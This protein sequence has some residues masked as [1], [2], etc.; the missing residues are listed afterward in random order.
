MVSNSGIRSFGQDGEDGG[1]VQEPA[2]KPLTARGK[3]D[4][5]EHAV[6]DL[7]TQISRFRKN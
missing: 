4:G 6:S 5:G 7:N 3:D 2:G 1:G